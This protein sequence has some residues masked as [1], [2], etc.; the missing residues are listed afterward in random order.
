[1]EDKPIIPE[2]QQLDNWLRNNPDIHRQL[3]SL[4]GAWH[5]APLSEEEKQQSFEHLLLK[6]KNQGIPFVRMEEEEKPPPCI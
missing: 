3:R 6:M 2:E 1:M 4:P 5:M